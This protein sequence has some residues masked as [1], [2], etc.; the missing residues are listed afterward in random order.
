MESILLKLE[1]IITSLMVLLG[2]TGAIVP[3]QAP[4]ENNYVFGDVIVASPY[5][6]TATEFRDEKLSSIPEAGLNRTIINKTKPEITL[7]KWDGEVSLTIAY[8]GV[9]GQGKK[10]LLDPSKIEWKGAKQEVHAY[11]LAAKEGMEDGGFEIEVILKEKPTTSVFDFQLSG[12][13]DLDFFYQAPLWQEAGL[14]N[15]TLDCTDTNCVEDNSI[16]SRP[17][18]VVGSYAV[19]HKTKADHRVGSMNYATGKVFHIYRPKVIDAN[20]VEVWAILSYSNGVLSITVPQN[21]LDSAVYP[22]KID[23]TFGYTTAGSSNELTANENI[24]G[25][26][27]TLSEAG[28]VTKLTSSEWI[29]QGTAR[30][31]RLAIYRE[32]GVSEVFKADTDSYT[33][34]G[35]QVWA[36]YTLTPTTSLT[37]DDYWLVNWGDG[38]NASDWNRLAYDTGSAEKGFFSTTNS[39]FNWPDP[40]TWGIESSRT[41]SIYATYT[42]SDLGMLVV[43]DAPTNVASTTVTLNATLTLTTATSTQAHFEYATSTNFT[44]T[45]TP[46]TYN[47]STTPSETLTTSS[48]YSFSLSEVTF[49]EYHYRGAATNTDFNV[50]S[51]IDFAFFLADLSNDE[52]EADMSAGTHTNTT[53]T[54]NGVELVDLGGGASEEDSES[55]ENT[56]GDWTNDTG[57]GTNCWEFDTDTT[58]SSN[59]GPSGPQ[60][61]TYYV[62]TE[63]SGRCQGSDWDSITYTL[64]ETAG[65]YVDFYYHMYGA[66]MGTLTLEAYNG[67]WTAFLTKAGQ[68]E[69][70]DELDPWTHVTDATFPSDTQKIRFYYTGATSFTGD[71]GLDLVKVNI[72]STSY[73]TSGTRIAPAIDVGVITPAA[74]GTYIFWTENVPA[75][76]TVVFHTAINTSSST[77]PSAGDFA[78]STSEGSI[79]G[80]T[81]GTD[82]LAGKWL[83]IKT[84]L[85]TT[86]TSTTPYVGKIRIGLNAGELGAPPAAVVTG[87][88]WWNFK[89]F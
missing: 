62:Y 48:S 55:F 74:S 58:G 84:F 42:A 67:S 60:D 32:N 20:E 17:E 72:D 1:A 76:T 22:V 6:E 25:S 29:T 87:R 89:I 52:I 66:A 30:D 26:K 9:T 70:T 14:D 63:T 46:P 37:V 34:G 82:D 64:S 79:A 49:T 81:D 10:N 16:S 83:W 19:Y 51:D 31:H 45:S 35:S 21:F 5:I 27:F 78:T 24:R 40:L 65:G 56:F 44:S 36:D 88:R 47:A 33:V 12:W 59:T 75:S 39:N 86:D 4:I 54:A 13:E 80:I 57:A 3:A 85:S 43:T 77:P 28:D 68:Q 8:E 2:S 53:S 50:V 23:P 61:G 41:F 73:A 7:E 18:N 69:Q 38:T 15:P 11:P 71:A